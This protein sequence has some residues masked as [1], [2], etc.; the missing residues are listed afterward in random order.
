MVRLARL[1]VSDNGMIALVAGR[2]E[3]HDLVHVGHVNVID[4]EV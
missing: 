1:T 3:A 4:G 2:G